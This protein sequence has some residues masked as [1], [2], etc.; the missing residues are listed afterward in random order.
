MNWI[1]G[2][3]DLL[4]RLTLAHINLVW[5]PVVLSFILALPLGAWAQRSQRM[6]QSLI[7][8]SGLLYA[9][10]SLALF[11]VLPTV[12]GTSILSPLNV[13]IAMT[14]Y[15]L[16]LQV[17]NTADALQSV[18]RSV[19]AAAQAMG[20]SNRHRWWAVQLPL[21]LPEMLTGLRVVS[22]STISLV[23]VGAL[24]GVESLGTLF[25]NGFNRAFPTEVAAGV[26]GTVVLAVLF[27][28]IL[29][30]LTRVVAPW[31]RKHG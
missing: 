22:A 5:P 25:T 23:S 13:I 19:L 31:R 2:N 18:D 3:Q 24:I 17:R 16:A 10:P 28:V 9:I 6:N 21:A 12:I 1:V 14:L 7:I 11:V 20:Y 4:I 15:G 30:A 29:L 26:I 27:D 8:G